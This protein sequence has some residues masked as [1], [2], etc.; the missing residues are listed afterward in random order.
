MRKPMGASVISITSQIVCPP[1]QGI[2]CLKRKKPAPA[3]AG[4]DPCIRRTLPIL[5]VVLVIALILIVLVVALIVV[6][7][8]ALVVVL[9]VL[10]VLIAHESHLHL[11]G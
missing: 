11:L 5:A 4:T 2:R 1:A 9:I 10:V 3:I 7:V 6:L 8:V